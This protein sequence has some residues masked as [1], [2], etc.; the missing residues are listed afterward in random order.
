PDEAVRRDAD[1]VLG[2]HR[3]L[4]RDRAEC[5]QTDDR[6]R[7]AKPAGRG[8]LRSVP[9]RKR[10]RIHP[11]GAQASQQVWRVPVRRARAR[12]GRVRVEPSAWSGGDM[13][14]ATGQ[15]APIE[16]YRR[17]FA[18]E[19]EACVGLKTP[20]LV[21]AFATIPRERFLPP[22]PW[23]TRS[24]FLPDMAARPQRTP[25]ADPR[26]VYHNVVLAIDPS[27]QLFNGQPGTLGAWI[28]ALGPR[29]GARGP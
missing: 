2:P 21:E 16:T 27:R 24:D 29:P 5:G 23:V 8:R 6:H 11:H 3:G 13:A 4:P 12:Q 22:G 1:R 17:F 19:I 18:E 26:R 15:V 7:S 25:D 9:L 20:A 28:D 10:S 14:A